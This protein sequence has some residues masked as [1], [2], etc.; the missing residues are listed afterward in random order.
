MSTRSPAPRLLWIHQNFVSPREAGNSR[1][2]LLVAEL[3][4]RGYAVDVVRKQVSYWGVNRTEDPHALSVETEGRL[5]VHYLPAAADEGPRNRASSYFAFMR[6]A[7]G[8]ARRL[9]A[10]DVVFAS[11]PPLPQLLLAIWFAWRR[12]VP[13][14]LEV[15]DLWPVFV[16]DT[17]QLRSRPLRFAMH[18]LEHLAYRYASKLISVSPGFTQYLAGMGAVPD[19]VAVTGASERWIG[20]EGRAAGHEWRASRGYGDRTVI[21]YTGSFNRSH[22]I[23]RLLELIAATAAPAPALQWVL[24][25][26]GLAADEVRAAS[27]RL[28]NLDY[29]GALPK[30]A[31]G[32][33]LRGADLALISLAPVKLFEAVVPG[34]LFDYLA[35]GLPVVSLVDGIA[36]AIVRASGGGWVLNDGSLQDLADTLARLASME[37]EARHAVG[38]RGQ[39]WIL[40]H[41]HGVDSAVAMGELVD[42]ALARGTARRPGLLRAAAGALVATAQGRSAREASR[43]RAALS[44]GEA[45]TMLADWL[46]RQPNRGEAV[47]RTLEL[48]RMLS[49]RG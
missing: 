44:A 37:P 31:L 39:A 42:E 40:A 1:A 19:L 2:A 5:S 49:A 38:R 25:G 24:A 6:Q 30:D 27:E 43:L 36:G 26:E 28:P 8:Y 3:L 18:W 9:P 33:V 45:D 11:S 16:I 14:V 12:K 48:P 32:P 22:G 15:R 13:M 21:V 23:D 10:P 34:K 4:R 7:L 35:A 47:D 29:L 41:M 46:E 20:E 17:G